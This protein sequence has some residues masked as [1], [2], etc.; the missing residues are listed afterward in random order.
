MIVG[1]EPA[2]SYV[3]AAPRLKME[4]AKFFHFSFYYLIPGKEEDAKALAGDFAALMKSKNIPDSYNIYMAIMGPDMPLLV[5]EQWAR[6][7]ADYWAS[8]AK[9][10]ATLGDAVGALNARALGLTRRIDH[11]NVWIRPDLSL[12]APAKK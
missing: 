5:V 11:E 1:H 3:A 10:N 7:E 6:D 8:E 2:M 9:N 12:P 4:E